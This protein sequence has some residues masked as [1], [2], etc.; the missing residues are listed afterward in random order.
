MQCLERA[1]ESQPIDPRALLCTFSLLLFCFMLNIM[2][3][4]LSHLDLY[5]FDLLSLPIQLPLVL[6]YH[7]EPQPDLVNCCF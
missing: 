4:V 3:A 2:L 5:D 1:F 7:F 6:C